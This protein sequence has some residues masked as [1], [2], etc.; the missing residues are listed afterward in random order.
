MRRVYAELE[1]DEE[2]LWPPESEAGLLD[3]LETEFGWLQQSGIFLKEALIADEDDVSEW[4]RYIG[5]LIEWAFNHSDEA[6]AGI[7][8]A[9]FDEWRDC[10]EN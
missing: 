6:S 10:D 4:A 8:P 5:Y 3:N 9:C 7:S 1:I 2:I